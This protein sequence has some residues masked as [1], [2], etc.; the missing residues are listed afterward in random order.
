[1]DVLIE[2]STLEKWAGLS[3]SALSE[4]SQK[5]S[6]LYHKFPIDKGNGKK[7]WIEAP[8]NQLKS[9]QRS[10]L[11]EVLYQVKPHKAAHG[12]VP[13]RSIVTNARPHVGQA[14][15]ANFDIKG[16][17]PATK[18]PLVRETLLKYAF[19]SDDERT[20]LVRLLCR[21]GSLPQGAPTSPHIANLAMYEV[22]LNIQDYADYH[23]L[24]YTRYAD[25]L[26]LSGSSLP[27]NLRRFV[28][29]AIRQ[30]GYTIAP[31]KS[32]RL[33][34]AQ[35]Q[36]V[37][38]LVVNEKICLP[39]PYRRKLRAILHDAK[40][41]GDQALIKAGLLLSQI[42]GKIALQMMWDEEGGRK[43]LLDLRNSLA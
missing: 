42:E 5:A 11:T 16:F 1:M 21:N 7:R 14:W 25:D 38:G 33:G 2:S 6:G 28:S 37:T 23:N 10:I 39:R 29:A 31:G 22:D 15:V 30:P 35:R 43:Q 26:T 32:K 3:A 12:F 36:M 40:S 41:N 13:G 19:L 34:K 9:V 20:M 8:S 17:F 4:L 18:T 27:G 24:N